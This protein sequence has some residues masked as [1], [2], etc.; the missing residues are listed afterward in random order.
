MIG[1]LKLHAGALLLMSAMAACRKAD[2]PARPSPLP[3]LPTLRPAPPPAPPRPRPLTPAALAGK[4]LF[5]D[6]S[7]SAS[8][9]MACSTCHDPDRAY[10]PPNDLPVQLGGPQG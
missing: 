8:G 10:G 2:D 4:D 9:Q 7:L 6:R 3:V 1:S 5:F